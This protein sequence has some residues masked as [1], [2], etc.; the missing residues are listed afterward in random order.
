MFS[1]IVTFL[2]DRF[3]QLMAGNPVDTIVVILLLVALYNGA[4]HG[5]AFL[6]ASEHALTQDKLIGYVTRLSVVVILSIACLFGQFYHHFI[7]VGLIGLCDS[8][9]PS[10]YAYLRSRSDLSPCS[11]TVLYITTAVLLATISLAGEYDYIWIAAIIILACDTAI[12]RMVV[13]NNGTA[14][15]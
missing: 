13:I 12:S 15:T 6:Q 2:T 7:I 3:Y 11:N 4:I 10:A 8:V 9:T 14:V 5:F 1:T